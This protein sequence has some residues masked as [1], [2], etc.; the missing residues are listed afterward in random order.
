VTVDHD[1]ADALGVAG[2]RPGTRYRCSACG[3]VTRFDVF[4]RARTRRYLHLD[5]AGS[6]VIEEEEVL[7]HE[8]EAVV[9][10]W[11]GPHAA[12]EVEPTPGRDAG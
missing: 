9:C 3:N 6:G 4:E 10:R 11:C 1:R 7:D 8:L 5:L 2:L 12:V